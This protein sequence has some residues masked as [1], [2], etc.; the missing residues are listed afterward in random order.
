MA[1]APCTQERL[2]D[3]N[4]GP[5]SEAGDGTVAGLS[6]VGQGWDGRIILIQVFING[7]SHFLGQ[8]I[9]SPCAPP[10]REDQA[11]VGILSE[12]ARHRKH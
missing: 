12:S 3:E 10:L 7:A 6:G 2:R 1:K 8:A 9:K 5:L 4:T 11:R